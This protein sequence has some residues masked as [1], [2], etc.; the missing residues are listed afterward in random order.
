MKRTLCLLLVLIF[1]FSA[2]AQ[3]NL[4]NGLVAQYDFNGN[5]KDVTGSHDGTIVN[6]LSYSNDR[7]GNPNSAVSFNG[8]GS[9][10]KISDDGSFSTSNISISVWF[11]SNS[12]NLQVLVGKR[13]FDNDGTLS[14]GAQ[15]QFFINYNLFPGI[16]SNLIGNNSSCSNIVSSSYINS[17]DPIC[18]DRWY[19]AVITY[20]GIYH[21]IYINGVLKRN[22]R[23]NFNS[24]LRCSSELRL[25]VWWA[26]DKLPFNGLMDDF[27]WYNRSLT[28]EEVLALYNNYSSPSQLDFSYSQTS[29]SPKTIQFFAPNQGGTNYS[30]DFGNG[31]TIMNNPSPT[32]TY[33]SYGSY[34]VKLSSLGTG[35]TES[36]QKTIPVSVSDGNVILTPDT[37]ICLGSTLKLTTDSGINYCW[38]PN[39][40]IANSGT[41][42]VTVKPIVNTTYYFTTQ[43]ETT[44]L[45]E[46]GDFSKGNTGFT[47]DYYSTSVNTKSAEYYIE[48]DPY[49]WNVNFSRCGDHTTGTGKMMMVNGSSVVGSKIWEQSISISPNTN[50]SFSLWIGSLIAQNPTNLRFSING[51]VLVNNII[52]SN[53]A[54]EWKRVF[55]T[56]NSGSSSAAVI[57]IINNN[58][59]VNGNDFAIDDISFS[60]VFLKQDSINVKVDLPPSIRTQSDTAICEGSSIQLNATGGTVYS[61]SP[62]ATLSNP[63]IQNP[64]AKPT[65]TTSY[66]VSAYNTPGCVGKD[67]VKIDIL[68]NPGILLSNDTI[69]CSGTQTQL[70]ATGGTEYLWTPSK[71]LSANNIS[72]PIAAPDLTTTYSV[73]LTSGNGCVKQGSVMVKVAKLPVV[74]TIPDIA[75]CKGSPAT[76]QTSASAAVEY[77]WYPTT[78]LNNPG[79]ASPIASPTSTIDYII[80]VKSI[81]N[82]VAKDTVHISVLTSPSVKT[83]NDTTICDKGEAP[84]FATGGE[85]YQWSPAI[86][87]SDATI[88]NPIASINHSITYTVLVTSDNGC[89]ASDSVKLIVKP[90]PVF[91]V[92]PALQSICK[93]DVATI[94][95]SGGEV[96]RWLNI[97][98][99]NANAS[100]AVVRPATNMTYSV[101]IYDPVCNYSDT[102]NASII[103]NPLPNV[104]ITKSN[105]IDCSFTS[106]TLKA[107]GGERYV[108]TSNSYA[109]VTNANLA[110]LVVSPPATSWYT[111]KVTNEN[112]CSNY[113]SIKLTVNLN[114]GR[115]QYDLPTAFTPNNDGKNDC[116]GVKSW[117]PVN[118]LDFSIFNRWGERVFYTKNPS[119]CWNGTYKNS[120][121]QTGSFVYYIRAKTLCGGEF[122]RKGII[123]LI[124]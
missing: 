85:K 102:L 67:T 121:Q 98:T 103:V 51:I 77:L 72:N 35:C 80:T 78:G 55:T 109:Q 2:I 86:G 42:N 105:D 74:T 100:I 60:P 49:A 12:Q 54:C 26:L 16:G 115:N 21:K 93:K 84:L 41:P 99:G 91:K 61:W 104:S 110:N 122:D 28:Q 34:V 57:A 52:S 90:L 6:S 113:D 17:I 83:S 101:W 13:K 3:I 48:S 31:Q 29:C 92:E 47:S 39:S 43:V 20:D 73:R 62:S 10:I 117:G 70:T 24:F 89:T 30:W 58:N 5:V 118:Q 88:N 79:I 64:V 63:N 68:K 32:V 108:W 46:N 119:D 75:L 66:I 120:Q 96:Y 15:Y 50:Y 82:C 27:R 33:S 107:S 40:S 65:V 97:D 56:W 94:N 71:G 8:D 25:G 116:F 95:A 44:N 112:G 9:Y 1:H 111:V 123:T 124:R 7:F 19:H 23:T 18:K 45:V 14:G 87:L 81:D 37:T 114:A 59:I 106:A 22:E 11:K 38:K 69:I 53:T 76:L 36:I 4:Q